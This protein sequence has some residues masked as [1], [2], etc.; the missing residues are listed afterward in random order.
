MKAF[1]ALDVGGTSIS[2]AVVSDDGK[3]L[4]D[5]KNYL[6]YSNTDAE[7]VLNNLTE[8]INEQ[9][10]NANKL[11]LTVCGVGLAFPGPFDYINGVSLMRGLGKFDSIYGLN[12]KQ[13]LRKRLNFVTDI[14]FCNDADLYTI[15]ECT[16]GKG[17]PYNRCMC[18]C[19]GT[20]IGSGFF[21]DGK[22]LKSGHGVPE[23]GWIYNTPYS[24]GIADGYLSGSWLNRT[25]RNDPHLKGINDA[26]GLSEAARAGN[27][28]AQ[29]I[30]DEFGQMLCDVL[31]PYAVGFNADCLILGGNVSRSSELFDSA[32]K[33][34]LSEFNIEVLSSKN[35][36]DN[37]LLAVCKLFN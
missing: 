14:R 25:V 2:A 26:K 13:E 20:G 24:D 27:A 30:F 36:S 16:F 9:Y 7:T 12:L 15:G 5:A 22:L 3:F 29:K 32:L 10:E 4:T 19:I 35:F 6:A 8:I 33:K 21:A 18:V 34:L 28:H 31:V 11:R 37:T 23:N 1:I 17:K